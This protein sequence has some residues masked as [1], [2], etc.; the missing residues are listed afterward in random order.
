MKTLVAFLIACCLPTWAQ[1][2]NVASAN[3]GS[4]N[5]S[6]AAPPVECSTSTDSELISHYV[7]NNAGVLSYTIWR[8]QQFTND[9]AATLTG[10]FLYVADLGADAGSLRVSIYSDDGSDKPGTEYAATQVTTLNSAVPDS[11]S[12][13]W[14]EFGSTLAISVDVK[15]W[16]VVRSVGPGDNAWWYDTGGLYGG[17]LATFSTDAGVTWDT[18]AALFDYSFRLWGCE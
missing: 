11:G 18:G 1:T 10:V 15:Y 12:E 17:G 4:I 16:I 13:V 6:G 3:I 9:N 2:F 14:F 8:A 7:D 5:G